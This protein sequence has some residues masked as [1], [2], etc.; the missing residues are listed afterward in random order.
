MRV[1]L[2]DHSGSMGGGFIGNLPSSLLTK[3]TEEEGKLSAAKQALLESLPSVPEQITIFGFTSTTQL[4]FEGSTIEVARIN[5]SL[6]KL[7]PCN[8]TN[9]ASALNTAADYINIIHG[10]EMIRVQVISD[11]LSNKREATIAAQRISQLGVPIDVI[12]I[13]ESEEGRDVGKAIAIGGTYWP[14]SSTKRKPA[15]SDLTNKIEQSSKDHLLISEKSADIIRDYENEASKFLSKTPS[16][17]KLS[18]L[19]G[20]PQTIN[21]SNWYSFLIYLHLTD[22]ERETIELLKERARQNDF[23]PILSSGNNSVISNRGKQF[24]LQPSA[25]GIIFNPPYYDI[26]WYED[27]QEVKFRFSVHE[28]QPNNIVPGC[29][30]IFSNQLLVSQLPFTFQIADKSINIAS[31]H[32]ISSKIFERVFASYSH[33]DSKTVD[34]CVAAYEA[35]GIYVY[36]D[37]KKLRSGQQWKRTLFYFIEQSD[38]F[39]LF[40]SNS[41]SKSNYVRDEWKYAL[42]INRDS[43]KNQ[44]FIRPLYWQKKL[45]E[46]PQEL[47]HIHFAYL[48]KKLLLQK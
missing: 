41:S 42:S 27:I 47:S 11:G 31:N 14:V 29:V 48:D 8:G 3:V 39:Q 36:I 7:S 17:E 25:D 28:S 35:L 26:S 30:N 18:F 37:K 32:T 15:K 4:V 46:P 40:W 2:L 45:P 5:I 13:D 16:N 22:L 43:R 21:R 20:F 38:I 6:D 9:I 19:A 23:D 33:R 44:T 24:R 1:V 12:L 10:P 34:A